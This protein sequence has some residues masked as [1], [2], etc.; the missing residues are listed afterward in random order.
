MVSYYAHFR[1]S[2]GLQATARVRHARCYQ[3]HE[4]MTV[5]SA[6]RGTTTI[7]IQANSS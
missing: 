6:S 1:I 7:S 2:R 4:A 5:T 3:G